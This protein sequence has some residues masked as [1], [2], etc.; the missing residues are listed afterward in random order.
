LFKSKGFVWKSIRP[1][2]RDPLVSEKTLIV[3]SFILQF[4]SGYRAVAAGGCSGKRKTASQA[5][6]ALGQHE[7]KQSMAQGVSPRE[8]AEDYIEKSDG[9]K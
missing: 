1:F 8:K 6:N 7:E 3:T 2:D 5:G 4:Q 9:S